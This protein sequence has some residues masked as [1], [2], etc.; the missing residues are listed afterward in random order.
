MPVTL[1]TPIRGIRSRSMNTEP[2]PNDQLLKRFWKNIQQREL[3]PAIDRCNDLTR[4]FP[5][6]ASSWH[7]ACHIAQMVNQ[8][9]KALQAIERALNLEPDNINWKLQHIAC[10]I[11]NGETGKAKEIVSLL[12][13]DESPATSGTTAN[14]SQLA[15]LCS[16]LEMN[17][18]A[19]QLYQGLIEKEPTQG[20]HWYNLASIQRFEGQLEMA[21]VSLDRAIALNP[22]DF[23]AYELRSGLRKQTE[24]DNHIKEMERLLSKGIDM[25]AGEV[26]LRFALSKELEDTDSFTEAWQQL[27]K[28]ATLRRK[29]INYK[30]QD[31]LLTI[32]SIQEAFSA[33]V[34]HSAKPG[35]DND[36]AIFVI[37][38]PR[39][40]STLV[41]R[42]LGSHKDVYAAGELNNFAVNMMQQVQK[43]YGKQ[44]LSRPELVNKTTRLSFIN[45]GWDYIDSTRPATGHTA[46]FVDKMPLNFLYA[47]LIHMALPAAKI[48]HVTRQPMDSCYA[49][50]K[51]LF[52]DGYPW[53]YDLDEIAEYYAAYH[54][55]M[56]HWNN[57]MPGVIHELAYESLVSDT[58][59]ETRRLLA[60]CDLEWDP[61]CLRFHQSKAPSTT[62]S[63]TQVRQPVYSSSVGKWQ[64]YQ[65]QLQSTQDKLNQLGINT[66][67]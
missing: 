64:N 34:I 20:G 4:Q 12:F 42:I 47:G 56:Q 38:L 53:S 37:G 26:K 25:P 39:T 66:M 36:E 35:D 62:A 41:E 33:E 30:S 8:P 14:V 21:E 44:A 61:D 5:A 11:K 32:K 3:G 1:R 2:A 13:Q 55:L 54:G 31:D 27:H 48:I 18:Q 19:T 60:H 67:T 16:Q 23:D 63:S 50:Y 51:C 15:F 45:L 17:K 7:A 59:A 65:Q 28:G 9:D 43:Q 40:G 52:E 29:H 6:Q 58:E 49:I 57:A 10:L 46:R 24:D 22:K